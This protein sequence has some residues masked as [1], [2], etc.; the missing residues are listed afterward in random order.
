[1]GSW[2]RDE[3]R[4]PEVESGA[5]RSMSRQPLSLQKELHTSWCS[6]SQ[7][8]I[9]VEGRVGWFSGND[10][11]PATEDV[12]NHI[13]KVLDKLGQDSKHILLQPLQYGLCFGIEGQ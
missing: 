7:K 8:G 10:A 6:H 11:Q 3:S 13:G 4:N 12:G 9:T 2:R 1:M 5:N